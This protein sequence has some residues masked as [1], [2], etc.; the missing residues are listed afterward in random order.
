M[1]SEQN[2]IFIFNF[3]IYC[4]G[5]HSNETYI[6][7]MHNWYNVKSENLKM[8]LHGLL[9]LNRI[10]CTQRILFS[11]INSYSGDL[12]GQASPGF[13]WLLFSGS[14][15]DDLEPKSSNSKTYTCS[16]KDEAKVSLS[17]FS[18]YFKRKLMF[19]LIVIQVRSYFTIIFKVKEACKQTC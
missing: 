5:H 6:H 2:M 19:A 10:T 9:K 4:T 18:R 7:S 11:Q 16:D 17:I 1:L 8:L 14:L 12:Q 3:S 15:S 13:S